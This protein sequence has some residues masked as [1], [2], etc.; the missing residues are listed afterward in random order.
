MRE[1]RL[2]REQWIPADPAGVFEFFSDVSN[3]AD[4]VPPWLGFRVRT[5]LPVEMRVGQQLER[6]LPVTNR[7]WY[8]STYGCRTSMESRCLK[9]GPQAV[10]WI[11]R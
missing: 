4:I 9:S 6:L 3:L 8:C 7:I 1:Y 2:E 11:V 10:N 5:P